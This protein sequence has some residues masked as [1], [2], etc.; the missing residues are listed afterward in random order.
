MFSILKGERGRGEKN[1]KQQTEE[2]DEI[3]DPATK[4]KNLG[5]GAGFLSPPQRKE[6][7][8]QGSFPHAREEKKRKRRERVLVSMMFILG[9]GKKR[10]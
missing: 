1:K 6:E 8:V 5:N 9:E 4:Q 2:E 7:K 10:W 3:P